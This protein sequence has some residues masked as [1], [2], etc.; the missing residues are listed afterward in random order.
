[1]GNETFYWDGLT[2]DFSVFVNH[3]FRFSDGKIF[4]AH[5]FDFLSKNVWRREQF[6]I[7]LKEYNGDPSVIEWRILNILL[8]GWFITN[9]LYNCLTFT[10]LMSSLSFCN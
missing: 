5:S 8:R 1:M 10:V 6:T 3:Q 7:V 2:Q 9:K 4:Q